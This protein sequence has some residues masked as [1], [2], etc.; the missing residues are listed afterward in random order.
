MPENIIEPNLDPAEDALFQKTVDY[1][2]GKTDVSIVDLQI[3]F[4]IAFPKARSIM[5]RLIRE[6]FVEK[7]VMP[8]SRRHRVIP[9]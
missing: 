5:D 9:R 7:D 6:K 4:S 1:L 3:R 2:S 8:D